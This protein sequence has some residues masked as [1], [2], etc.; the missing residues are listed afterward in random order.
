MGSRQ[1]SRERILDAAEDVVLKRGAAHMTLDAVAAR[2]RVSKG[3]L[4]Y[5]FPSQRKLL[6]AMVQRFVDYLEARLAKIRA[7]L[8]AGP[9]REV[10]AYIQASITLEDRYLR[11][12][13]ALLAAVTREPGLL[14]IA[15]ER[16]RKTM[17]GLLK[18]TPNSE[19]ATVLS[20]AAKGVFMS[21][22]LGVSIFSGSEREQIKRMLLRLAD[23]WSHLPSLTAQPERLN[24]REKRRNSAGSAV[25]E[26]KPAAANTGAKQRR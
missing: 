10:K 16:H 9:A 20:L 15:R 18:L 12:A 3:G 6:Q 22:L 14:D 7:A 25:V 8:P 17:A 21:E 2:A 19:C 5:H 1:S 11:T 24:C 13:T 26:K 4:I 23:A